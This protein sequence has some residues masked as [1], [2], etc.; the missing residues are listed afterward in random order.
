ML[1]KTVKVITWPPYNK[2]KKF[3]R[4]VLGFGRPVHIRQAGLWCQVVPSLCQVVPST[5][6][7]ITMTVMR[8]TK[9]HFAYLLALVWFKRSI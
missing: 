1:W 7:A 5:V 6:I 4:F 3:V 8:C 2:K 9:A